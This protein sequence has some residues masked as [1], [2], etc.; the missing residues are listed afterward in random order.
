MVNELNKEE[1]VSKDRLSSR[2][3]IHRDE[4]ISFFL[5]NKRLLRRKLL[6]MTVY[7]TFETPFSSFYNYF[8]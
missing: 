8:L 5:I 1:A 6:A 3:P 7:L 4:V 2:V